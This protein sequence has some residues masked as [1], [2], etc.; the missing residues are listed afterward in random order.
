MWVSELLCQS[1]LSFLP[2]LDLLRLLRTQLR[3]AALVTTMLITLS[4]PSVLSL[5]VAKELLV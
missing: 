5:H 1:L 3:Y 2:T 4:Q